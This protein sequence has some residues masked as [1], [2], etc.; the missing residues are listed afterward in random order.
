MSSDESPP[1]SEPSPSRLERLDRICD[2]FEAAW[3]AG[4]RPRIAEFLGDVPEADRI[5]FLRELIALELSLRRERGEQPTPEDYH[6][7]FPGMTGLIGSVFDSLNDTGT[8]DGDDPDDRRYG[9]GK[10]PDDPDATLTY[11]VG[12]EGG[13]LGPLADAEQLRR[14]TPSSRRRGCPGALPD[15]PGA[16]QGGH[17]RRLPRRTCGSTA[18]SRSRPSSFKGGRATM[19]R[20]AWR[21]SAARSPRRPGWGPT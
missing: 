14:C 19:T 2:R 1:S 4:P 6:G 11:A 9:T 7:E 13:R 16:G 15:R 12:R 10:G 3:R 5:L 20:L 18:R 8:G 17:G 21:R